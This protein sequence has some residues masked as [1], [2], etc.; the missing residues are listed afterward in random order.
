MSFADTWLARLR[1]SELKSSSWSRA[2]PFSRSCP[3]L[4]FN[5]AP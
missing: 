2:G 3:T 4:E 5:F 1:F